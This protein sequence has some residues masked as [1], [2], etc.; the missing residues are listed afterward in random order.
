[1]LACCIVSN[2]KLEFFLTGEIFSICIAGNYCTW[3]IWSALS[4]LPHEAGKPA[5]SSPYWE[6]PLEVALQFYSFSIFY[7][8][9]FASTFCIEFRSTIA[10]RAE[11]NGEVGGAFACRSVSCFCRSVGFRWPCHRFL[12]GI[13]SGW[14]Y[15]FNAD[16]TLLLQIKRSS[17]LK[18]TAVYIGKDVVC[19]LPEVR[20][21]SWKSVIGYLKKYSVHLKEL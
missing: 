12:L 16:S 6:L 2:S 7:A 18:K 8:I 15:G 11:K 17:L 9:A 3:L 1:M 20:V 14:S 5:G 10:G 13:R 4:S 19:S 21:I